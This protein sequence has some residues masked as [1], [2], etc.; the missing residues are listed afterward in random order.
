MDKVSIV[1]PCFNGGSTLPTAIDGIVN[2]TYESIQFIFV[3][4]GSTDDSL[5]YVERRKEEIRNR[6]IE[7]IIINQS[8]KGLGGAINAGLQRATGKY[9]AWVDADDELI[10]ES[11]EKRVTF[12]EANPEYGSVS[13]DAFFVNSADWNTPIGRVCYNPEINADEDQFI[14]MLLGRS[15]FC[16]GCHLIRLDLFIKANGGKEIF[17]ARHGQNWQM[18]LP[19]YYKRKHGYI[20]EPLYKYRTGEISMTSFFDTASTRAIYERRKEYLN[21]VFATLDRIEEM[22]NKERRLYKK[23]FKEFIIIQ[24]IDTASAR[25]KEAEVIYWRLRRF[26]ETG[27]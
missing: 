23:M 5:Q 11:I 25:K 8:N 19:V 16:P 15:L 20:D 1:M 21:L 22:N 27:K 12:L 2:Q 9:L 7:L 13:S 24:N 10:P 18:L 4:D 26:I 3:N 6:G 17:P 14:H